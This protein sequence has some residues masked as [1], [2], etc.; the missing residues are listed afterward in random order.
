MK[1]CPFNRSISVVVVESPVKQDRAALTFFNCVIH[2]V[3]SMSMFSMGRGSSFYFIYATIVSL[4]KV[5][6]HTNVAHP[7]DQRKRSGQ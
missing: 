5:G 4:K 7:V 3:R 2:H 1:H 6:I